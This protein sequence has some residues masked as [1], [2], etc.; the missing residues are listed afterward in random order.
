[1]SWT[2][3]R[4]GEADAEELARI[5]VASWRH[6]YRGIVATCISLARNLGLKVVAEGVETPEQAREL[7]LLQCDYGQGYLYSRPLPSEAIAAILRAG[8]LPG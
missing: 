5:N 3:R 8:Q 7:Q 6:A 1:M 2:V 4:A